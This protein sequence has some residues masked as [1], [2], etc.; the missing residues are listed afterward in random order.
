MAFL[1]FDPFKLGEEEKASVLDL[2]NLFGLL[3]GYLATFIK[4]EG[5][6]EKVP[7]TT[8]LGNAFAFG[9]PNQRPQSALF[10]IGAFYVAEKGPRKIYADPSDIFALTVLKKGPKKDISFKKRTLFSDPE[11]Q[12]HVL[13]S[14]IFPGKTIFF[15]PEKRPKEKGSV[16]FPPFYPVAVKRPDLELLY[17]RA[18]G[19]VEKGPEKGIR[20]ISVILGVDIKGPKKKGYL[21]SEAP[22]F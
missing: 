13:F 12:E 10:I 9:K 11:R 19:S 14:E 5:P 22:V 8:S 16:R 4:I 20:I 2:Q 15:M 18:F 6:E 21:I 1:I 3:V 17:R 7:V